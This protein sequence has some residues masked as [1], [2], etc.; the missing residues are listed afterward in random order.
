MS[1]EIL[2]N[3]RNAAWKELKFWSNAGKEEREQWVVSEFLDTI[4]IDHSIDEVESL[5]QSSK[6]DVVFRDANF[7]VKEIPNPG[8]LKSRRPKEEYNAFKAVDKLE[9]YVFPAI[10][11]DSPTPA[12]MYDLVLEKA[13]ELAI[14][15][16]YRLEKNNI[17]LLFYIT[18]T[19]ASLLKLEGIVVADFS[20]LGWRSIS[21]VNSE[22]A[23]VLYTKPDAPEFI[24]ALSGCVVESAANNGN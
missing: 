9:D 2:E 23:A 19:R 16:K 18:R 1:K 7:Q 17:D 13:T 20:N 14:G 5:E 6:I 10:A 15:E 11:E 22:Q 8:T 4:K 3:L 24:R 12:R 21:C